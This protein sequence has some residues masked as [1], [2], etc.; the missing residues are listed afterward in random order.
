MTP[1][2]YLIYQLKEMQAF[3]CAGILRNTAA[4]NFHF[5]VVA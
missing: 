2:V 1:S 4:M 5:Q 3:S